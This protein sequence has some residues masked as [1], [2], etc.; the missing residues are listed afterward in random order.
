MTGDFTDHR[1][2]GITPGGRALAGAAILLYAAALLVPFVHG[3]IRLLVIPVSR[4]LTLPQ[5]MRHLAQDQPTLVFGLAVL[6]VF[7]APVLLLLAALACAWPGHRAL[8]T[9]IVSAL[10][11]LR[12]RSWIVTALGVTFTAGL[13]SAASASGGPSLRMLPGVWFFCAALVVA[14]TAMG[15]LAPRRG[16]AEAGSSGT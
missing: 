2:T 9:P 11:F 3:T 15:L 14:S 16:R 1:S 8:P 5:F 6:V 4:S 12:W 10:A 13:R 7:V